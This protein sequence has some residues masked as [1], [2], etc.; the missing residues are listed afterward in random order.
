MRERR[1]VTLAQADQ[2]F[3][4]GADSPPLPAGVVVD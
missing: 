4:M 3:D 1:F 2:I